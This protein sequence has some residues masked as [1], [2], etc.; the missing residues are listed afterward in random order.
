MRTCS[1]R[2]GRRVSAVALS[3]VLLLPAMLGVPRIPLAAAQGTSVFSPDFL[4]SQN[5]AQ[6]QGTTWFVTF[7]TSQSGAVAAGGTIT[8]DAPQG[9]T[10]PT[11]V[12]DYAV[13]DSLGK[14]TSVIGVTYGTGASGATEISKTK[15]SNITTKGEQ[16]RNLLR[17]WK[18]NTIAITAL[19]MQ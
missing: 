17:D 2:V 11:A 6:Q 7:A 9:T 1:W 16:E 4:P 10:W 12:G 19:T 5:E 3:T 15:K 13:S 8:L 14:S 18:K